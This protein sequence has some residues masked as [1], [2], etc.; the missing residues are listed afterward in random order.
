[1]NSISFQA[2]SK[3]IKDLDAKLKSGY[4]PKSDREVAL[5]K[6][7]QDK[8][9][10]VTPENHDALIKQNLKLV[11]SM[12][13][14]YKNM[15]VSIEDLIGAGYLGLTM[16]L[17]RY[18][19]KKNIEKEFDDEATAEYKKEVKGKSSKFSSYAWF[20]VNALIK[21]E[22]RV[23]GSLVTPSAG[24]HKKLA[25]E[26]GKYT[27]TNKV[28]IDKPVGVDGKS[29]VLDFLDGI[30]SSEIDD[31]GK[32]E[33]FAKNLL[34]QAF[35]T[36]TVSELEVLKRSLGLDQPEKEKGRD[37]AKSMGITPAAVS[38]KKDS[39]IAKLGKHFAGV[40]KEHV[41]LLKNILM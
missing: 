36:L 2:L 35:S 21:D 30:G 9:L 5:I 27:S 32:D 29:S 3:E 24:D 22:L 13:H 26:Q 40:N 6:K 39:A 23:S 38:K 17:S 7:I 20:W 33:N 16:A 18:N 10:P 1:M 31:F 14:K 15:G 12:A 34:I 4:K 28:S 19:P 25:K 11:L 37:I 41:E 8:N